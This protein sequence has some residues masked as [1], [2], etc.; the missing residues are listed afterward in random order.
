MTAPSRYIPSTAAPPGAR[1][2]RSSYS[3][4]ANNCVETTRTVSGSL[5]VRDSKNPA[6]GTLV[7]TAQAWTSFTAAVKTGEITDC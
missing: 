5:A 6:G 7:F 3:T 1:W 4:G 2:V